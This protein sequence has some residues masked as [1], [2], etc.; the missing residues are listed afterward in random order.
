MARCGDN[1]K[2]GAP[3]GGGGVNG[4]QRVKGETVFDRLPEVALSSYDQYLLTSH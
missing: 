2:G 1:G 3:R 4:E